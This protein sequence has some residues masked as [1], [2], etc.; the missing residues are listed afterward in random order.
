MAA[1][2]TEGKTVQPIACG[3]AVDLV[4]GGQDAVGVAAAMTAG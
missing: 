2:W 4:I 3:G 1:G